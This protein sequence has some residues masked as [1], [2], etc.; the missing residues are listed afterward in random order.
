MFD[1]DYFHGTW[2]N[3]PVLA[4]FVRYEGDWHISS[5]ILW[6][7]GLR[8]HGCLVV[9]FPHFRM[10]F[11]SNRRFEFLPPSPK[12]VGFQIIK[13]NFES[14][15]SLAGYS[16][17]M[18]SVGFQNTQKLWKRKFE[19]SLMATDSYVRG[20]T[21]LFLWGRSALLSHNLQVT[22]KPKRKGHSV[23]DWFSK[24]YIRVVSIHTSHV[25]IP[26]F[27]FVFGSPVT[28]TEIFIVFLSHVV[29]MLG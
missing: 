5:V 7:L 24:G 17:D 28:L 20:M 26:A 27:W 9:G 25:G 1:F 18:H 2:G 15:L 23:H 13:V 6:T 8:L 19:I 29:H 14:W 16:P 10:N 3:N 11:H 21:N 22:L 4:I 12:Y